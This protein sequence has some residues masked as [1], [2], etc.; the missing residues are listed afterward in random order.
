ML[1]ENEC[2]DLKEKLEHLLRDFGNLK[3]EMQDKE[4]ND[5]NSTQ[6]LIEVRS[7]RTLLG[8]CGKNLYCRSEPGYL[9]F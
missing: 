1:L 7:L 5:K 2:S 6:E 4:S 3:A 8:S 9:S